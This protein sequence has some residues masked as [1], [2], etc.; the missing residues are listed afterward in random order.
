MRHTLARKPGGW[1]IAA[2]LKNRRKRVGWNPDYL[3][4]VIRQTA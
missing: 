2:L 1:R 3:E 4:T